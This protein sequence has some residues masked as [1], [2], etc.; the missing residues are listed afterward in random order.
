MSWKELQGHF[1]LGQMIDAGK[2][3]CGICY[4]ADRSAAGAF[5][6]LIRNNYSTTHTV[7]LRAIRTILPDMLPNRNSSLWERPFLPTTSVA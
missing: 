4:V 7:Q 1:L 2:E 3:G 6:L 5:Q